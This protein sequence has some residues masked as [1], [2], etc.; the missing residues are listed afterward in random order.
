[1]KAS[2]IVMDYLRKKYIL[3]ALKSIKNQ[4]E[5]DLNDIEIIVVKYYQDEKI[6]N[7][8]KENFP[9]YKIINLDPNGPDRY[10][11]SELA[12]GIKEASSNLIFLLDDDDM[13]TE[14][15]ISRI[16]EVVKNIKYDEYVIWNKAIITQDLK[17]RPLK[18]SEHKHIYNSSSIVLNIK[19]KDKLIDYIR[20]IY[21]A[22][23]RALLCYFKEKI[24][25]LNDSLTYYRRFGEN[26]SIR[27]SRQMLEMNL[28]DFQYIYEKTKCKNIIDRIVNFKIKLNTMYNANYKISLKEYIGGLLLFDEDYIK[29]LSVIILYKLFRNYLKKYYLKTYTFTDLN[30][31][32]E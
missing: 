26:T 24:I 14:N 20:K 15:K 25:K 2:V 6:D 21:Y 22:V 1:M 28:Q 30:V 23:D 5:I 16:F 9:N 8:I 29:R 10:I 19:D 3:D 11:G 12:I 13:F 7:Y 31:Q 17:S 32:N 27:F 18:K 4:K